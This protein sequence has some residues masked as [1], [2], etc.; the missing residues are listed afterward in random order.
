MQANLVKEKL[1][2]LEAVNTLPVGGVVDPKKG[3][4]DAKEVKKEAPA[5][6]GKGGKGEPETQ[7]KIG[8]WSINPP[9]GSVAP[10]SSVTVEVTFAGSGQKL[11]EQKLGLDIQNRDPED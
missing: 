5:K 8:Q 4:K 3:K 9:Q 7:L 10:D 2:K 6:K 11:Y 1:A